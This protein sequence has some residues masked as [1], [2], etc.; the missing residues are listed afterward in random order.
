MLCTYPVSPIAGVVAVSLTSEFIHGDGQACSD[1]RIYRFF[2]QLLF[3]NDL[4]TNLYIPEVSDR[5][6]NEAD[7]VVVSR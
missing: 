6:T 4:R 1:K 3:K 5:E 2:G 7:L